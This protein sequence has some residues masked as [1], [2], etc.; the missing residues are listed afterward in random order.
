VGGKRLK[1]R[2]GE[3]GEEEGNEGNGGKRKGG[4]EI[5]VAKRLG[6]GRKWRPD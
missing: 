3:E 2:E 6:G 1:K 4:K 5:G